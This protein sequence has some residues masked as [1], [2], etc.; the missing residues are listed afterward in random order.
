M[1]TTG[2]TDAGD[3]SAKLYVNT[4]PPLAGLDDPPVEHKVLAA[5]KEA[6]ERPRPTKDSPSSHGAYYT[7]TLLTSQYS[8]YSTHRLHILLSYS[9]RTSDMFRHRAQNSTYLPVT[10]AHRLTASLGER[11]SCSALALLMLRANSVRPLIE[12][13]VVFEDPILRKLRLTSANVHG[14]RLLR[15]FPIPTIRYNTRT[16]GLIDFHPFPFIL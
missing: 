4:A 13:L 10:A 8:D 2:P 15:W 5:P 9:T 11:S 3:A 16:Y 7:S 6:A 1:S 12:F 14:P